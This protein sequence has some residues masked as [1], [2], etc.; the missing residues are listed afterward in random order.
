MSKVSSRVSEILP[1]PHEDEEDALRGSDIPENPEE[2]RVSMT[3]SKFKDVMA[4]ALK[5]Q[6]NLADATSAEAIKAAFMKGVKHGSEIQ[7]QPLHSS[8][9]ETETV[10]QNPIAPSDEYGLNA[11]HQLRPAMSIVMAPSVVNN[12]IPVQQEANIP[13]ASTNNGIVDS[14]KILETISCFNTGKRYK[15]ETTLK[16]SDV[17]VECYESFKSQFNIHH[18][19]LGWDT[20]RAGVELYMSLEGKAALNV[21]EVVMNA[22]GMSNVTEMWDTIGHA[23]LLIEHRESHYRQFSTR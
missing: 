1:Q 15:R 23:F 3:R 11:I 14:N 19:M 16:F 17:S 6:K 4:K 9:M 12:E 21:E 13:V 7:T 5:E 22:D 18:K 2:E 20:H 8:P 10:H